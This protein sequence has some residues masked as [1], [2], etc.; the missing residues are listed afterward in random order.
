MCELG[1]LIYTIQT[2]HLRAAC[3]AFSL[4]D[5]ST[6]GTSTF[7]QDRHCRRVIGKDQ[8][9]RHKRKLGRGRIATKPCGLTRLTMWTQ[10]QRQQ[11]T[12]SSAFASGTSGKYAKLMQFGSVSG[13]SLRRWFAV[14]LLLALSKSKYLKFKSF[15]REKSL[16]NL[17][18]RDFGTLTL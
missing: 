14:G 9:D 4:T 6:S 10:V 13:T 11:R 8:R 12:Q 7:S 17:G 3:R 5:A 18:E 2:S 1:C 16:V 15:C